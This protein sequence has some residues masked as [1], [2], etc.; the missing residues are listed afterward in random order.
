MTVWTS[1]QGVEVKDSGTVKCRHAKHGYD[2]DKMYVLEGASLL[3]LADDTW[4]V[5]C[6]RCSFNGI[7]G[8][9]PYTKPEGK[10][11]DIVKQADSLL[12]HINGMHHPSREGRV[13]SRYT[14]QE[15]AAAI[16]IFLKWKSTR[17]LN[18]TTAA[19]NDLTDLGFKPYTSKEW[20]PTQLSSLVR[21][22]Q[23]RPEF[24][25]LKAAPM[26]EEDKALAKII[27]EAQASAKSRRGTRLADSVRI[28]AKG[29]T[30]Q[31]W[32]ERQEQAAEFAAAIQA[33]EAAKVAR[34]EEAEVPAG[35]NKP[36]PTTLTFVRTGGLAAEPE[37]TI[38]SGSW[39][40]PTPRPEKPLPV[41]EV[42]TLP[43]PAAES[44]FKL[45]SEGEDGLIVF[46]YK[47]KLYGGK[48][49]KVSF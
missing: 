22:Y 43:L 9:A 32:A 49:A 36:S 20:T 42:T 33:S 21:H 12:A 2:P 14:N 11:P 41:V 46:M 3:A 35:D 48:P 23:K 10:Y 27:R 37:P 47:G 7:T 30:K 34:Q 17:M 19:C 5:V 18:W 25:N 24:M 1:Y 26:S 39:T 6:D 13:S 45:V 28:T 8:R 16:K 29:N 4:L 44:D 15:I 31:T 38:R 40:V